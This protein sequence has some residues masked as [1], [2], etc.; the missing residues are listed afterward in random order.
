MK[1]AVIDLEMCKVPKSL[2]NET[3]RWCYE[4]IQIGAV[5]LDENYDVKKKFSTFVRP[6]YGRMDSFIEHLTGITK[7]NVYTAKSFT[8]AVAAFLRWLPD[9][10]VRCVSWSDSDPK[11]IVHEV[12]AKGI[13]D[14]RLEI[15]FANW[16]DCQKTFGQKMGRKMEER[17]M[18]TMIIKL[19]VATR[20]FK[21]RLTPSLKK[22]EA[23]RICTM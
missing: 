17:V 7:E 23:G 11:Q 3:Y 14:E 2:R 19:T 18:T 6:E 4:T 5:L 16:M 1:Y 22:V 8:E 15:I 20:F 21:S 10:E 12:V 13:E 9:E